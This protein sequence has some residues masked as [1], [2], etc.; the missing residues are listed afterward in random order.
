MMQLDINC[1]NA[2][3]GTDVRRSK[4][5]RAYHSGG[6]AGTAETLC[7]RVELLPSNDL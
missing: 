6:F 2:T 1:E 7:Y 3:P 5:E 4:R